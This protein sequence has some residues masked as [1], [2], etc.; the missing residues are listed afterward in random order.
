[1]M[2]ATITIQS[3]AV[4]QTL[5]KLIDEITDA[6]ESVKKNETDYEI[7]TRLTVFLT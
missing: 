2:A 4:N 5:Q 1:M 7:Q 6:L 3:C